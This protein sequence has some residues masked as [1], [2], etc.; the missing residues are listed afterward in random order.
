MQQ[1]ADDYKV[2]KV[3]NGT[4]S[5]YYLRLTMDASSIDTTEFDNNLKEVNSKVVLRQSNHPSSPFTK[6]KDCPN[7]KSIKLCQKTNR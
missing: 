7:T 4:G 2:M 3:F 1:F 5:N 6:Y